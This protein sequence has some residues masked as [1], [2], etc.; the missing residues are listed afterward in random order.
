MDDGTYTMTRRTRVQ[1]EKNR[2]IFRPCSTRH[3][4]STGCMW[5]RNWHGWCTRAQTDKVTL[6]DV[7]ASLVTIVA[8]VPGFDLSHGDLVRLRQACAGISRLDGV[9]VADTVAFGCGR[10]G[11]RD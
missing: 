8:R 9:G 1:R 5:K 10:E 2:I 6:F 3:L 7:A 4:R 11:A